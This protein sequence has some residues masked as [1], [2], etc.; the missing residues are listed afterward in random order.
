[1]S[2]TLL[3]H[4]ALDNPSPRSNQH[5]W[6]RRA[7]HAKR[8][9]RAR[10]V[11]AVARRGDRVEPG[12]VRLPV[13]RADARSNHAVRLTLPIRH[14]ALMVH[15]DMASLPSRLRSDDA[16]APRQETIPNQG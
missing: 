8:R 15:D 2:F 16:L 1:M 12:A 10:H 7:A 6:V 4:N 9:R 14:L 13:L 11:V 5:P 3:R